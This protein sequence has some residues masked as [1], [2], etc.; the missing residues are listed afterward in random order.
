MTSDRLRA[1]LTAWELTPHLHEPAPPAT[2]ADLA[3]AQ[4]Q[5][6]RRLPQ[7]FL[8]LYSVAGGGS[9]LHGNL[10]L[11]PPLPDGPEDLA[12]T[13]ASD[14]MRSWE[15]EIPE[16]LVIIGDNGGDE[17][18]GL[19]LPQDGGARPLVVELAEMFDDPEC[20]AIMGDLESF[21][22]AWNVYYLLLIDEA[23]AQEALLALGVPQELR[24]LPEE[25]T[26]EELRRIFAWAAPGLPG[27]RA[28]YEHGLTAEQVDAFAR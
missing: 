15:W 7:A 14:L 3:T 4:E 2:E 13:T 22:T 23:G 12:L 1:V 10:N 5:L 24:A 9:F 25:G 6:G 19:W 28:P 26:E 21:L 17:H 16:P 18:F 11:L 8:D 27:P 20:L